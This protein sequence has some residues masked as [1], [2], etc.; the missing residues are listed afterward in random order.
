MSSF[1]FKPFIKHLMHNKQFTFVS[2]IGFSIALTFVFLLS[3]YIKQELSVDHFQKNKDRIYRIANETG[4]DFCP[5]FGKWLKELSP[6]IESYTRLFN[7]RAIIS[8]TKGEKYQLNYLLADSSFFHIFSYPFVEGNPENALSSK[9]NIVL[10]KSF[11]NKVFPGESPIGQVMKIDQQAFTVSA[12]IEDFGSNTQ[13]RPCDAILD[14]RNL[15]DFWGSPKLMDNWGNCSFRYYVMAKENTNLPDK[16]SLVLE[17]CKE[18]FW[19]YKREYA[20][21]F[22]FEKLTD[23]YFSN[24]N[25][26]SGKIRQNSKTFVTILFSIVVFILIL[27]IINNVNLSIAQTTFRAKEIAIKK[28]MGG[29]RAGLFSQLITESI[30]LTF[31]STVIGFFLAL[32]SV[33]WFNKLVDTRLDL[34]QMLTPDLLLAIIAMLVFIGCISGIFPAMI[35]SGFNPLDVIKGNFRRVTKGTYTKVLIS[36]QYVVVM[37]LLIST[38]TVFKQANYLIN[39]NLGF[40]KDN[41]VIIENTLSADKKASLKN[42]WLNIPGVDDVSFVAGSPF[43]GGNN[44]SFSYK[45]EPISFQKF[46]VDSSFFKMLEIKFTP[47]GVAYSD[48]AIYI[49][50][51]AVRKLQLDSLPVSF[52]FYSEQVPVIG[53]L[54]DFHF[55]NLHSDLGMLIIGKLKKEDVPWQIL[56]KVSGTNQHNTLE[57]IRQVYSDISG[58]EP[59]DIRFAD[60]EINSWYHKEENEAEI[61]AVFAFLSII[62]SVMGLMAIS[63]YFIQQRVKEIG[64]RKVNGATISQVTWMLNWAFLKWVMVAMLVAVPLSYY[65]VNRWLEGF[66]YRISIPWEIFILAMLFSFVVALL[67]ISLQTISAARKNPVKSLRY[68]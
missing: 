56:I 28:L 53:V 7:N 23:A 54:K 48:D 42:E 63:S 26:G 2:I 38:F 14:F 16:E 12:V 50:K 18:H 15:A 43:D 10:S 5:P 67:T 36:F 64:I 46:L 21:E 24:Y 52:D 1:K 58:G 47:T 57:R 51:T 13:L 30:V 11:A 62:L 22:K 66:V 40:N 41:V 60:D 49:N 55:L 34:I 20:K 6:E 35:L 17:Q 9:N 33:S 32:I 37:V 31:F 27:S 39:Y 61:I 8:D 68:E 59:V 4:S 3:A 44:H 25:S 45:G 19:L 29:T 65:L